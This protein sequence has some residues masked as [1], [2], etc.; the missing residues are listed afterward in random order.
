VIEKC[1]IYGGSAEKLVLK[2]DFSGSAS[3]EFY[4]TGRPVYDPVRR[5]LKLD[6]LEYDIRSRNMMLRS[7]EWMFSG[8]ILK[9][10]Q[11]YAQVE[12]TTYEAMLRQRI[13]ESLN[14]EIRKGVRMQG[15]MEAVNI[16][17]IY[18]FPEALVVRFHSKGNLDILINDLSF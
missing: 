13:N 14:S 11:Q 17:K 1:S 6:Q 9:E 5:L 3:G 18:P 15:N 10:L 16:E 7:A 12:I 8:R 2:V 4:L